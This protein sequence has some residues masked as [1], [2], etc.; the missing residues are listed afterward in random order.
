[1]KI[2]IWILL[3]SICA[4]GFVYAKVY[5]PLPGASDKFDTEGTI[6]KLLEVEKY[7][8]VKI[9]NQNKD[10]KIEIEILK[11]FEGFVKD[12]D[13]KTADLYNYK[14]PFKEMLGTSSD[15]SI[16]EAIADR[17]SLK[18]E[19]KVKVIQT[20]K[21]DSFMSESVSRY[22][23]LSPGKFTITM[24]K[25]VAV[26]N[27]YGGTVDQLAATML[28]QAG[29]FLEVRV[30]KDTADTSIIYISGKKTGQAYKMIFQGDLKPMNELGMLT[31]GIA[32]V[33]SKVVNFIGLVSLT[34]N[35]PIMD[36]KQIVLK[37]GTDAEIDLSAENIVISP[38]T[39]MT[40]ECIVKDKLL[41]LAQ[42]DE[43]I[44][45]LPDE[46]MGNITVSNLIN[47]VTVEGPGLIPFFM[48]KQTPISVV[49][50]FTRIIT[51]IFDDGTII[52]MNISKSGI[53][54]NNLL[55]Q[56]GK[57][58]VKIILKNENT[59]R[60]YTLKDMKFVTVIDDGGIQPKNAITKA[61]D[62]IITID[63]IKI[64]R[65]NNI[66][67]DV[68][69]GVTFNLKRE[70][71]ADILVSIDHDYELV[72]KSIMEWVDSYDKV[73]S[74]LSI[75]TKPNLDKTPLSERPDTALADGIYQTE[76]SFNN[77][78]NMLR[79]AIMNAYVTSL[80][81]QLAVLAQAGIYTKKAGQ[82]GMNS[83][84]FENVKAG[85]LKV[86]TAELEGA[87]KTKFDALSELFGSDSDHD[88]IKDT[89][90]AIAAKKVLDFALGAGG[91]IKNKTQKQ[92]D[93]MKENEKEI[94]KIKIHLEDYEQELRIKYGKMNQAIIQSQ[95]QQKWMENNFK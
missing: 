50:N 60:D 58:I 13:N 37:Q 40:F 18:K 87:L 2:K 35:I 89:G 20:A 61:C 52:P 51:L 91:F 81:N 38:S 9:E 62:A 19:Y 72:K 69:Q 32:K 85:I 57:R 25:D 27:F 12:F 14:S 36:S 16:V 39:Y 90:V 92:V 88:D 95:A 4:A 21:P 30:I 74:Y 55:M 71:P 47:K 82:A 83:D 45:K 68:I 78:R 42:Q 29:D 41:A 80:G 49:S 66:I 48:E 76:S 34:T 15:P 33:E 94:A 10:L 1:M 26:I 11:D 43:T 23:M 86:D 84:E 8:M 63:G 67:K 5:V 79:N 70:S 77:F 56:S 31:Q 17:N 22:K 53:Y 6:Q 93:K 73:M 24:G 59:H 75:L 65:D 64:V 3:L 7:P 28:E 54:T 46:L 44:P